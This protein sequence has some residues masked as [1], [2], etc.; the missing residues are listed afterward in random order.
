MD[1]KG[2]LL[3]KGI[4]LYRPANPAKEIGNKVFA[5]GVS[6]ERCFAPLRPGLI[7]AVPV[8]FAS[9]DP[10]PLALAATE[11]KADRPP[12]TVVGHRC[13]S[14]LSLRQRCIRFD[15]CPWFLDRSRGPGNFAPCDRIGRVTPGSGRCINFQGEISPYSAGIE[16]E[17][18]DCGSASAPTQTLCN[19]TT[20]STLHK[21]LRV[22]VCWY[23]TLTAIR[24]RA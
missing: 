8:A 18:K 12:Q 24:A 5:A 11:S 21:V 7:R 19:L 16:A 15:C 4:L 9:A 6:M 17:H 13:R 14:F 22:F 3:G 23:I 10:S 2:T 20:A 1:P